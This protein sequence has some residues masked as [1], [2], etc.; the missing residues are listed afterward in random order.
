MALSIS[1]PSCSCNDLASFTAGGS[2]ST[3]RRIQLLGCFHCS[4]HCFDGF[5]L[6]LL[7]GL[8]CWPFYVIFFPMLKQ[9]TTI[10]GVCYFFIASGT[11]LMSMWIAS[12]WVFEADRWDLPLVEEHD[13]DGQQWAISYSPRFPTLYSSFIEVSMTMHHGRLVSHSCW[14]NHFVFRFQCWR[15]CMVKRCGPMMLQIRSR[16][17]LQWGGFPLHR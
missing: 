15:V 14:L 13:S 12:L 2:L 4:L 3:I 6:Y 17:K 5:G 8:C 11:L 9:S 1:I 7:V 10:I 16:K